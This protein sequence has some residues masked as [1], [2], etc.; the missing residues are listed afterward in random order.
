MSKV[1]AGISVFVAAVVLQVMVMIYG[2][3]LQPVSWWWILGGGVAG[4]A[5]IKIIEAIAREK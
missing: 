2:W 4:A 3:G 5:L 1:V